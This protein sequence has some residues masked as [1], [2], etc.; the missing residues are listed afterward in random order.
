MAT[1]LWMCTEQN[2][3]VGVPERE[4]RRRSPRTTRAAMP[5]V[6]LL[7]EAS[8]ITSCHVT[9]H[10]HGYGETQV[11]VQKQ[12]DGVTKLPW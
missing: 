1:T 12:I 10:A 3:T 9:H 7:D 4:G 6:S 2:A 8:V 5:H 11:G